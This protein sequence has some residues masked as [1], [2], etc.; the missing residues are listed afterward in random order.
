MRFSCRRLG[1]GETTLERRVTEIGE[2][3]PA[4]ADV[5]R[6]IAVVRHRTCARCGPDRDWATGERHDGLCN[7]TERVNFPGRDVQDTDAATLEHAIHQLREVVD[8]D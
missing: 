8:E 4:S 6:P 7:P 1:K 5:K 3:P 2:R